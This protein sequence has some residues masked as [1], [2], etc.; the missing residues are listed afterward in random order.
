MVLYQTELNVAE[1]SVT[2]TAGS[3]TS[4][5]IASEWTANSDPLFLIGAWDGKPDGFL[6]AANQLRM[7]PSDA[8]MSDWGPVTYTVGSS[9]ASSVPMA[10]F[11]GLNDPLTITLALDAADASGAATLRVGTT[12]S[13][14][15]GRPSITIDSR[16]VTRGAYRGYGEIYDFA[17]PDGA[18]STDN[19]ITISVVSGSS[20]DSYLTPNYILD[21]I[22]L[23]R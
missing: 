2:V 19:T 15:G 9:D 17:I 13:F 4:A 10:L 3:A 23:F 16:G 8:R 12:L 5:D 21:A 14:A 7:H 22:E 11:K 6:N 18:L 20:G 1:A